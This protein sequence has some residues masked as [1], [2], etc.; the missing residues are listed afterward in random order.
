VLALTKIAK[1]LTDP[2]QATMQ[3]CKGVAITAPLAQR[4]FGSVQEFDVT[5][6]F[7]DDIAP[8]N[9]PPLEPQQSTLLASGEATGTGPEK[10]AQAAADWKNFATTGETILD[11]AVVMASRATGCSSWPRIGCIGISPRLVRT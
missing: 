9:H 5:V 3:L 4:A 1:A 7:L 2:S 11:G 10:W 6:A 8:F